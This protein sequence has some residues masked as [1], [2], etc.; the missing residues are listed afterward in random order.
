MSPFL[1]CS[2]LALRAPGDC[3]PRPRHRNL[4]GPSPFARNRGMS[5]LHN[6]AAGNTPLQLHPR[7]RLPAEA[8]QRVAVLFHQRGGRLAGRALVSPLG[9]LERLE[10][11]VGA[12]VDLVGDA[13]GALLAGHEPV[14]DH[15]HHLDLVRMSIDNDESAA[16]STTDSP[17]GFLVKAVITHAS[18]G[19][20]L[21]SPL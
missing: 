15:Q 19:A 11:R 9:A 14:G 17:S 1:F 2:A 20:K 16:G 12:R 10:R 5:P 6:L 7:R 21:Y 18:L 4:T 13:R 8:Q 3:N